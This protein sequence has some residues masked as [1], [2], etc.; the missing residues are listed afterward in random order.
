MTT[1]VGS[2]AG[3]ASAV[4]GGGAGDVGTGDKPCFVGLGPG[5]S[6]AEA[7]TTSLMSPP[8]LHLR[9]EADSGPLLLQ[10]PTP[11]D[12]PISEG[13]ARGQAAPLIMASYGACSP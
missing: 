10:T 12:E 7:D 5:T 6:G 9:E 4:A 1:S 3:G 8:V 13:L 11:N 2:P